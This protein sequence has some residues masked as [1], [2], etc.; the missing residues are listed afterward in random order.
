MSAALSRA[1]EA[2]DE[3]EAELRDLWV[4]VYSPFVT[5]VRQSTQVPKTSKRKAR[6]GECVISNSI[7]RAI[8]SWQFHE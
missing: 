5:V 6:G 7:T 2:M 1:V 8:S 3:L 4:A